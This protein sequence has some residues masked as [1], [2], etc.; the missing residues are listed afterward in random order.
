[1]SLSRSSSLGDGSVAFDIVGTV[2]IEN[3]LRIDIVNKL[4]NQTRKD[5]SRSANAL[6]KS[7]L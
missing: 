6:S 3:A 2:D 5:Q 7:G 4:A 1:M